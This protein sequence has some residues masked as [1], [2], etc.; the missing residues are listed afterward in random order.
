MTVRDKFKEQG[1][2]ETMHN[3]ALTTP[4][5][6]V[7]DYMQIIQ[8]KTMDMIYM[9]NSGSRRLSY[10][11]ENYSVEEIAKILYEMY[12]NKWNKLYDMAVAELPI[13]YNYVETQTENVEDSGENSIDFTSTDTG[14]VNAYNDDDFVNDKKQDIKT[15]NTGS[16]SNRK[17]RELKK[18]V[19][20]GSK[21]DNFEKVK[22][23]LQNNYFND[24][25]IRDINE[26][27]TLSIFE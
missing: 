9:S 14:S 3:L 20:Q 17:I 27:I 8:P 18:E 26:F 16:N 23:Y 21:T 19:L 6:N 4:T 2:F 1:L 25:I 22:N 15:T 10:M 12:A 24:I 13:D 11:G 7:L 5:I